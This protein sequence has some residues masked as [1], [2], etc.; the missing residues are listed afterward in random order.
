LKDS[1]KHNGFNVSTTEVE[2]ILLQHP[3]VKA[4]AMVGLPD[5]THGEIGFAFVIPRHETSAED[6]MDFLRTRLASFKLP[7]TILFVEEFPYTAGTGKVQKFQLKELALSY[8]QTSAPET[9]HA[10]LVMP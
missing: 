2:S 4:A 7:R 1:Y 3:A 10:H 6:V 5:R 8:L 9:P